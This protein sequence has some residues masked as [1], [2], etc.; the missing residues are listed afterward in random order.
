[1]RVESAEMWK[2]WLQPQ[3]LLSLVNNGY[4]SQYYADTNVRVIAINTQACD[5]LNFNLIKNIT[6]PS[7]EIEFL[8]KELYVAEKN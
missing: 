1:M 2:S 5:M 3:A 6:D 8:R 4:Y 7:A